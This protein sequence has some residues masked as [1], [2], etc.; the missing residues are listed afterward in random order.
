MSEP[1]GWS[2]TISI[3]GSGEMPSGADII[4]ATER[5]TVDLED[6]GN[7]VSFAGA[8]KM[9]VKEEPQESIAQ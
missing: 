5:A 3:Y 1:W 2:V 6:T 8:R 4:A 7:S 9:V